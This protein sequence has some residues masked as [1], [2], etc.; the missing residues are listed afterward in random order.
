MPLPGEIAVKLATH[1]AGCDLATTNLRSPTAFQKNSDFARM[2]RVIRI[3]LF[4]TFCWVLSGNI[5]VSPAIF[6]GDV[7]TKPGEPSTD[8]DPAIRNRL[9]SESPRLESLRDIETSLS[10][11]QMTATVEKRLPQLTNEIELRTAEMRKLLAVSLPLELL[12]ILE[13]ALQTFRDEL[14]SVES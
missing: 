5:A 4:I 8:A 14:S 6:R 13:L 7:K 2:R 9:A 12:H 11:D 3:G 10:T 1:G